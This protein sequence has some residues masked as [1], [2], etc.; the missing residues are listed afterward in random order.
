MKNKFIN[1]NKA[2][3]FVELNILQM[4][5]W[6]G[7]QRSGIKNEIYPFNLISKKNKPISQ[8]NSNQVLNKII[9]GYNNKEYTFITQPPGSSDWA[10]NRATEKIK[11][12]DEIDLHFEVANILEIGSGSHWLANEIIDTYNPRSY[13]SIDPV[14]KKIDAKIQSIKDY[15][16][17]KQL[18]NHFY[19][20]ILGLNVLEHVPEPKLFMESIRKNL[21]DNGYAILYFPD[22]EKQFKIGDINSVLHEHITYFT[23]KSVTKLVKET[24]LE[25]VKLTSENDL[26]TLIIKKSLGLKK[27]INNFNED[28]LIATFYNGLIYLINEF[29]EKLKKK[30]SA[31]H[32]VGFHGATQGLNTYLYL[33]GFENYE[34]EIFDADLNKKD[35]FLSSYKNPIKH[36]SENSYKDI[37]ILIVSA[38]SFYETIRAQAIDKFYISEHKILPLANHEPFNK[39]NE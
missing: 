31:G 19:D 17:S 28:D 30:I 4:P 12:L 35:K 8:I 27:G 14:L 11:I 39:S 2:E 24:G 15:Y 20:L 21:S 33:A 1:Y 29:S 37:D 36:V 32:K 22:C 6:K 9:Q 38:L 34:I 3:N 10:N 5:L 18:A 26:F 25:I 13:T 7:V 16:P 23:H